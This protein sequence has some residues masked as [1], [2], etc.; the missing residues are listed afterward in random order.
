MTGNEPEDR[1]LPKQREFIKWFLH[2][3]NEADPPSDQDPPEPCM[4]PR[5][6]LP[7]LFSR[8]EYFNRPES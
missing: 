6:K 8:A 5:R 4:P 3:T 1:F 2:V 7:N